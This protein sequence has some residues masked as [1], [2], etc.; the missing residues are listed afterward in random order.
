MQKTKETAY[1]EKFKAAYAI[2][3]LTLQIML[4]NWI[5]LLKQQLTLQCS[6]SSLSGG[7]CHHNEQIEQKLLYRL[8]NV[9]TVWNLLS[10]MRQV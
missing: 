4:F 3:T 8:F 9:L 1:V 10:V 2:S 6:S 7:T 5:R